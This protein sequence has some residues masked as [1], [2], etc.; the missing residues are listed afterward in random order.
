MIVKK[1]ILHL[2]TGQYIVSPVT[3]SM[4]KV[5]TPYLGLLLAPYAIKTIIGVLLASIKTIRV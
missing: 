1:E 2:V 5:I 4:E 3:R